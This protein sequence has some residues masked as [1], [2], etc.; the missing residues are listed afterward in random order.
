MAGFKTH[1]TTSTLVGVG[2]GLAGSFFLG[3]PLE[4]CF[5]AGGLCSLAGMLPDLDSD[6]GVPVRETMTFAAAIVPMLMID[7]FRSM[8]MTPEMMALAGGAIYLIVRFGVSEIFKRYT[9]HRGMWHSVPACLIAGL[10]AFL[11]CS[12]NEMDR[13]LFKTFAVMLGF[14][15]HLVLDELW[16][17]EWKGGMVHMKRSFG[18]AIKFF[19]NRR[20]ANVSTYGKLVL[21]VA[22]AVSDPLMMEHFGLQERQLPQI[23]HDVFDQLLR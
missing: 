4:S 23:A 22:V 21:L 6:T 16:S 2:Y 1:I 3:M 8:G 14:M 15:V 20:W 11:I 19:S 7:R 5:L 13:R 10:L 17:I 18:T 12:C 9:V